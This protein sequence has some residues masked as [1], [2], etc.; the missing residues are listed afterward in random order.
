M[1]PG[2]D[3]API[4]PGEELA[5]SSLERYLRQNLPDECLPE[6]DRSAAML[7]IEQ[8]PGGHSNL[9]YLVRFGARELVLRRPPFGPVAPTAHDMPREY[10]VLSLVH[11][12]FGLAPKPYLLCEDESILGVPFY[13]MERRRGFVLRRD[14]PPELAGR[15]DLCRRISEA[16]IDRLADL[17]AV[18]IERTGI[19]QIGKPDGFVER[20][21]RGW[22]GRWERAK[23]SEVPAMAEITRWLLERIPRPTGAS[24]V[25]NDF[26]LD[27]VMFDPEDPSRA[28]AILDWEMCTVGDPLVDLGLLLS[29]WPEAGDPEV[30]RESISPVTT[31]PGWLRRQDLVKRYA[32][33]T[34]C[35]VSE[36]RFYEAFAL[37][38]IAV[39]VQ[40]IYFRF[41]R[42][43]THD[44]R[45]ASFGPRA[46]GL[47][48]AALE[49]AASSPVRKESA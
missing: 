17:H 22:A 7:E 14:L 39:V 30:R 27:N 37:F 15:P 45:F 1:H 34:G 21:I 12:V 40:Q 20:Q 2:P 36:I 8:F 47:I 46:A 13:V 16:M 10:R 43:Q 29:Y 28:I 5:W 33:R 49:V 6:P 32:A 42:G 48:E 38:K 24:I 9:T 44:A 4:R 3:T 19:A 25:H 11:P 31:L 18:D 35:D 23:T 26:K 41:A